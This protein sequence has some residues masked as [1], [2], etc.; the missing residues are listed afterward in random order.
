MVALHE[1]AAAFD[2]AAI[3]IE[4]ADPFRPG[5]DITKPISP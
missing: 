4:L 1:A 2:Q 5:Y 3:T